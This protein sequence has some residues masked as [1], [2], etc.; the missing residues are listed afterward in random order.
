MWKKVDEEKEQL[1]DLM[2]QA[3]QKLYPIKG[4]QAENYM[5]KLRRSNWNEVMEEIQSTAQR[6][7][8]DS[9]KRGKAMVFIDRVGNHSAA[10]ESWLSLLPM[11]DYGSRYVPLIFFL[12]FSLS[13]IRLLRNGNLN[14]VLTQSICGV[15]KLA[16][17]VRNMIRYSVTM[18]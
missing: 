1:F 4:G 18:L 17:G 14:N 7:K 15:F 12:I 6:W 5:A 13:F 2:K 10:L 8:A 3:Q 9:G 16:I 11:G